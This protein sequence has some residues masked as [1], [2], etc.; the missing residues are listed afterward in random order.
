[1]AA[2][3]RLLMNFRL[4]LNSL[5]L[6]VLTAFMV[7][8]LQ[9][10]LES[11]KEV[12]FDMPGDST[13]LSMT[14]EPQNVVAVDATS[15][16]EELKAYL[17]DQSLALIISSSGDGRPEMLVYDPHG[18]LSWFPQTNPGDLHSEKCAAYLFRG[19][20]SERRW[21]VAGTTPLLPKEVVPAGAIDA[22]RGAGN[23]QYA[24]HIN[25][26]PLEPGNYTINTI[27]PNEVQHILGLL[28]RMGLIERSVQ[29]LPLVKYLTLNPLFII[30]VLFLGMG[31]ICTLLYWSLYLRGRAHEFAIRS[32]HG[33][34]PRKLIGQNLVGGLPGLAAGSVVGVILSGLLVAMI[35]N[36]P[37]TS[38]N[39]QTLAIAAVLAIIVA[40]V[41]WSTTLYIVIRS[42][43][44]VNLDA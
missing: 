41:T 17:C 37:L 32:C 9:W 4:A 43:Y 20:Y 42:R 27:D 6:G 22:P 10:V 18:L 40:T 14:E 38:G 35:G 31:H 12:T 25:Q 44:E 36:V 15:A 30:T 19:T 7:W 21:S 8:A 26:E 24:R 28:Q 1:M 2:N 23:L 13:V 5:F 39:Y 16:Q 33:A 34:R 11:R 29:T 3:Q